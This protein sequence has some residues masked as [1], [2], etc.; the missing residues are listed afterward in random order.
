MAF[1]T[2]VNSETLVSN[3]CVSSDQRRRG[4]KKKEKEGEREKVC[5]DV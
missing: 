3:Q 5:V 2:I 4:L 1:S